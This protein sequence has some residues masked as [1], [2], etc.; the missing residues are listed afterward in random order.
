MRMRIAVV[1]DVHVGPRASFGG[2][3]RKL[4]H[5]APALLRAF[6]ERMNREV[7]PDLVVHLGDAIEDE[8]H[9]VDLERYREVVRILGELGCPVRHV[10][11]N[12]DTITLSPMELR[13]AWGDAGRALSGAPPDQL[14]YAE[15]AGPVRL[16]VLHSHEIK[17][18]IVF[19]DEPQITWLERE[20]STA[21]KPVV[22]FC[23]HALAD[24]ILVGNRWFEKR[25]NL[26]LV[27][28]RRRVRD[29]VAASGNV[30]LVVNGHMH[31]N[32]FAVHDAI[33]YVTVQSLIENLDDD[34]PGRAARA[35]AVIDLTPGRVL[36]S[37][38]G[39][40]VARYQL[41]ASS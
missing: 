2:K 12:H 5:E 8:S 22:L 30:K 9:D 32:H 31:W 40:H 11:G 21:D 25:P 24:Q 33:G 10:A 19:L 13:D 15:D 17:D 37:L 27:R 7:K 4:T 3:L 38:D 1:T 18:E 36:V 39:E 14:Y 6:V 29:L 26:S 34:A 16:V 23:H 41:E 28:E 20:L 35:H